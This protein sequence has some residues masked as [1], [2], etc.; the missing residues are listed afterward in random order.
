MARI[1]IAEDD[2]HASE[3]IARICQFRGH[4]VELARDAVQALEAYTRFEP[5]LVI[6]D[7]AM[8]LGGGQRF[9]RE[10][11]ALPA[12]E[13]CPVIVI[14]GYAALLGEAERKTLQPCKILP[15]PLQ[16]DDMLEALDDALQPVG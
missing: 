2:P 7:L 15:K 16:L 5:Q 12:G 1:L 10:L 4:T 13:T 11:R 14:T 3:M 9:V 8:P 6:T